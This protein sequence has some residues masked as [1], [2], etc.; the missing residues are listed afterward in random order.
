M[1]TTTQSFKDQD[2]MYVVHR[3]SKHDHPWREGDLSDSRGCGCHALVMGCLALRNVPP[4]QQKR[5]AFIPPDGDRSAPAAIK[6][7]STTYTRKFAPCFFDRLLP[8]SLNPGRDFRGPRR[9]GRLARSFR[10]YVFFVCLALGVGR[11]GAG[12]GGG[13]EEA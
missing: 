3:L 8:F 5:S 12:V 7:F 2:R 6:P 1:F 10:W 4:C 13:F 9:E 11:E